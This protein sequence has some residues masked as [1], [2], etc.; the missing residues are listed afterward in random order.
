MSASNAWLPDRRFLPC[1]V[2]NIYDIAVVAW[3]RKQGDRERERRAPY[4]IAL[5]GIDAAKSNSVNDSDVG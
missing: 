5:I 4:M 1:R 2:S 3:L